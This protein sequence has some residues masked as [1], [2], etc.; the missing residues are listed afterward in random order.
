MRKIKR[1]L[2]FDFH[3]MPDIP[4]LGD[5]FSAESF[6][7]TLVD[8]KIR[9][10]NFFARCNTGFSYYP[11]K[12]GV[13]HPYLKGK[14]LFGDILKECHKHDI[15][16]TAYF[17]AGLSNELA[18]RNRHWAVVDS[19][20]KVINTTTNSN[21]RDMCYNT[22]YG[23]HL[24]A[25]VSEVLE[26]YP[27]VDGIFIDCLNFPRPCF[28]KEC[29]DAMLKEGVD[30][31][32]PSEVYLFNEKKKRK[33]AERV[34]A[35]V[36]KD[37]YF[38]VN[39]FLANGTC[40]AGRTELDSHAEIEC[41]PTVAG[42]WGYDYFPAKV[43]FERN[44]Y[45]DVVYM[46]GR[47][48]KS[49]GDFGGMVE[50]ASLEFDAYFALLNTANISIGD[51]LHPRGVPEK[52]LFDTVGEIYTEIEKTEKWTQDNKYV[53]E[54]GILITKNDWHRFYPGEIT[55]DRRTERGE[56]A[57]RG[58]CRMLSE[59][60]YQFDIIT[61]DM[62]ISK[63]KLLIIPDYM[64]F[65]EETAKKISKYINSGGKVIS[66]GVSGLKRD[67]SGFASPEWDFKYTGDTP[68]ELAYFKVNE[69]IG[70]DIP[71]MVTDTYQKCYGIEANSKNTILADYVEPYFDKKWDGYHSHYYA[72]Y[73]KKSDRLSAI[74]QNGSIIHIA[75]NIFT[76]YTEVSHP[77]HR[78]VI[79]NCIKRLYEDKL[80]K[81][82]VPTFARTS[83][84]SK[85][86][87]LLLHVVAYCPEI[88]G[89]IP[90]GVI[91][92]PSK[93]YENEFSIKWDKPPKKAYFVPNEEKVDFRYENGRIN[94]NVNKIV[95]HTIIAMEF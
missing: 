59:L 40:I 55:P 12:I 82:N 69:E 65:T 81:T 46:T 37:K 26:M 71:N 54:I 74:V 67:F 95:G 19:G 10:I 49:W 92:E 16:V 21:V 86:N 76:A 48:R 60:K 13:Q 83:L 22:E 62:D 91:D 79:A 56:Y 1:A 8:A 90:S 75:F 43:S 93:I 11:T 17:N 5:D 24:V 78:K 61:D 3:T 28:G 80:L 41:L 58:V 73:N 6:V 52:A 4:D 47:F 50:K 64:T 66:S 94:I 44:L 27:D 38:F 15:G 18:L 35:V 29:V 77:V 88:K 23:D 57:L 63:F 25:E 68:F 72:P 45:D 51:H 39:A 84:T 89:S 87:Y 34:R 9:Y 20:G 36:P 42:S 31:E 7:K 33:M 70:E 2:H 32:N 30:I 53:P 14:D 85:D